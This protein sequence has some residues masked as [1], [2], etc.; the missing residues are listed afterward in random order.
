MMVR[1]RDPIYK[2][3]HL[4]GKKIGLSKS[5]N[6]IKND[7]WR[8]QEEHGIEVMLMLNDM[9]RD[10]VQIVEFPYPDDWYDKPEPLT[11]MENPNEYQLKRD[12]KHDLAFRP[13]ETA[14]ENGAILNAMYSQSKVLSVLSE[15]TGKFKSIED[16]SRTGLDTAKGAANVPATLTVTDVACEQH[17]EL[18]V[19]LLKGLIKVGRW[20]NA[21]KRA[22]RPSSTNRPITGMKKTRMK[23]FGAS[24]W[25]RSCRPS[26]CKPFRS[27]RTS[28]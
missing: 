9:T 1:A 26:T 15:T 17:P 13:L 5:L 3:S 10:D 22:P 18:I 8:V 14:L 21:H 28:C 25:C 23:T 12:H 19:A 4:K 24:R 27:T 20:A 6:V 11:P 16:L 7:W 2:M